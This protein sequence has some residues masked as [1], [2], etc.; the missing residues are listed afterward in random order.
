MATA[1]PPPVQ[2]SN[3]RHQRRVLFVLRTTPHDV[4]ALV[5][6]SRRG[7]LFLSLD[8]SVLALP[9]VSNKFRAEKRSPVAVAA[10]D[11]SSD[12]LIYVRPRQLRG[13]LACRSCPGRSSLHPSKRCLGRRSALGFPS[14]SWSTR[15]CRSGLRAGSRRLARMSML[16]A[17][18]KAEAWR[19]PANRLVNPS[20]QN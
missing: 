20:P 12:P 19:E 11:Q 17:F 13:L 10:G 4:S 16:L 14:P 5:R 6:A 3:R 15:S 9:S 2:C 1:V 18:G 7:H 8:R